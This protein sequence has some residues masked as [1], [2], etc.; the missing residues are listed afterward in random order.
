MSANQVR[1]DKYL[2]AIR[3]FKTRGLAKKAC[4]SGKVKLNGTSQKPAHN[5][6][7]GETY[8]ISTST[9]DWVI[10]VKEL[11]DRRQAYAVAIN[12]YQDLTPEEG[13][14]KARKMA[15]SFYTGKRLSK[16]G[17]PTKSERRALEDFL[18]RQNFGNN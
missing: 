9:R 14:Q 10:K 11:L 5:V 2:W 1:L 12:Y 13:K 6:V 16:T 8:H 18:K 3:V 15:A 4:E 17:K 7:L